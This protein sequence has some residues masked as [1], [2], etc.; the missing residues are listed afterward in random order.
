MNRS[1]ITRRTYDGKPLS[2]ASLTLYSVKVQA[3]PK[4]LMFD[5]VMTQKHW[6][7]WSFIMVATKS[8]LRSWNTGK[9][10][11]HPWPLTNKTRHD[12]DSRN[13]KIG[14]SNKDKICHHLCPP[15]KQDT[16]NDISDQKIDPSGQIQ[17]QTFP[18]S[19]KK[20]HHWEQGSLFYIIL[21]ETSREKTPTFC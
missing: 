19:S 7:V 4:S 16:R 3:F 18:E 2:Y 11:H 1:K 5:M 13:I 6:L 17:T 12:R 21:G 9:G 15:Y 14:A 20:G 10:C 8:G